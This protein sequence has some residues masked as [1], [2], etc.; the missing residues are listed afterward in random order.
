MVRYYSSEII[1]YNARQQ[2]KI[3]HMK[4]YFNAAVSTKAEYGAVYKKIVSILEQMGHTVIAE[5]ILGPQLND[6]LNESKEQRNKYYQKMKRS[7][8]NCDIMVAEIS[9]PS[10]VHVGHELTL[11]MEYKKPVLALYQSQKKPVLFW[12][13]EE[14]QFFAAEYSEENLKSVL[15]ESLIY[16]TNQMDTRF[17]FFISP[18]IGHY[19]DWI[20]QKK[21]IPRSVYLR[22]L[23]EKEMSENEEYN[24]S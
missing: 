22:T 3:K 6:L 4:I 21:K 19:L 1:G 16:L 15:E 12:G 11:A 9:F 2:V 10:T 20:S 17:N 23:I 24:D 7:I 18:S 14:E 13:V 5:H 8:K